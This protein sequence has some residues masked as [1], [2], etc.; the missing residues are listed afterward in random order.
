VPVDTFT[1]LILALRSHSPGEPVVVN[2][3]RGGETRLIP[4]YLGR[5][6][7]AEQE[8]AAAR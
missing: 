4:I 2:I 8:R 6:P 3:V 1:A 7:A 5:R